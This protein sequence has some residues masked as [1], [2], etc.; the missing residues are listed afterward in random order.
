MNGVIYL[1]EMGT[2]E[3][4]I[5]QDSKLPKVLKYAYYYLKKL[6]CV[7]TLKEDGTCVIPY[8]EVQSKRIMNM[9][10]KV[11]KKLSNEVVLSKKL[12]KNDVL[13]EILIQ[14]QITILEGKKLLFYTTYPMLEY[15]MQM[16]Q[17][18]IHQE[19]ISIL[20]NSPSTE[21]TKLIIHL[22]KNLKRVNIIT[23]NINAFDKLEDYLEEE[24]GISI[25]ITNNKRKSLLKSKLILNMDF[26]EKE[27]NQYTIN[28]T[29]IIINIKENILIQS[30]SFLGINISDYDI[31]YEEKEKAR[32]K[33]FEPKYLYESYLGKEI[34]YETIVDKLQRD[35]VKII[36]LIGQNG[37]IDRKEY[38]RI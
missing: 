32:W 9:I 36:N 28:R 7:L 33:V 27:I 26:S 17:K 6:A 4:L 16:Q 38:L 14:N 37:I 22:A 13:K 30:K 31:R 19:E 29:A 8:T 34:N 2:L 10:A 11:V 18:N 1:K 35:K 5:R 20:I 23:R 15:I 3:E 24:F 25:T 12:I 21:N